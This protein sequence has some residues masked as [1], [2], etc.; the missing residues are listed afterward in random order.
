[1]ISRLIY[2]GQLSHLSNLFK[3]LSNWNPT[4][5][6]H[7]LQTSCCPSFDVFKHFSALVSFQNRFQNW[8]F[9]CANWF[10]FQQRAI[11]S[12]KKFFYGRHIAS[13]EEP[14]FWNGFHKKVLCKMVSSAIDRRAWIV[15]A[16]KDD[17]LI[18]FL[19]PH[20]RAPKSF[21]KNNP[22]NFF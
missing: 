13:E 8:I 15:P 9:S 5:V 12:M 2:Q 18:Q 20:F 6:W 7:I 1:M 10:L 11:W 16:C 22:S 3:S 17:D 4:N 14:I 21:E 19:S